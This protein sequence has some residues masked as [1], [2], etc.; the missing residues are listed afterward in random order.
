MLDIIHRVLSW[1]VR[2][3]A[4]MFVCVCVSVCVCF[5]TNICVSMVYVFVSNEFSLYAVSALI[6][7]YCFH[8][9]R[10]HLSS[11]PLYAHYLPSPHLPYL[12]LPVLVMTFTYTI[13]HHAAMVCHRVV[14]TEGSLGGT[15]RESSMTSIKVRTLLLGLIGLFNFN[16][17]D[18]N[19][20]I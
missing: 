5:I 14:L 7:C 16:S 12:S 13:T 9:L 19:D 17:I 8:Y 1:C 20:V 15:D 2:V 4:C 10:L 18:V 11:L 3:C 6:I